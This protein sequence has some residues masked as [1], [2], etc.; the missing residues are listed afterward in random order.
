MAGFCALKSSKTFFNAG[1][2]LGS[3][4]STTTVME[5]DRAPVV[6]ATEEGAL[7][8]DFD[9]TDGD[10]TA[11]GAA[12][13]ASNGASTP[14][15]AMAAPTLSTSRRLLWRI[16]GLSPVSGTGS[17]AL[18]LVGERVW[19]AGQIPLASC[20]DPGETR[21]TRSVIGSRPRPA[22]LR[23]SHR[24]SATDLLFL[25][26]TLAILAVFLG[27]PLVYG[28]V[29][30]LHDTQ[31]FDLTSF[32]GLDHYARA[33]FGDAVFHRSLVNTL[34]FTGVAV[35]LQ[36][37]LGLF[38]AVLLADARRGRSFFQFVFFV[39]FVLA[40]VA[41][42]AVWKFLYA[43]YFG[44]GATVGSALGFDTLTVAP[45]ADPRTALWGIMAAF[46]WRFAGFN[47]VVYLAAIQALPPGYYEHAALEGAGK[48]QKFR[49]ITWPL[50]WPQTFTLVLLTTLGTLRIFDMIWIM[51]GGGPS[52]A[53]ETVATDIYT[54]AFS[55]LQV[56]YAQAMAMILL[57]V[58][59][60][61]AVAEYR[62]LNR[63][64]EMVSA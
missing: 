51:T 41:V 49:H 57:V 37:G 36:T 55:F 39:P 21:Q 46:L 13:A 4:P 10:A 59:L 62:I 52:H 23:R 12:H 44:V 45:L 2:V 24:E 28:I 33:I 9:A 1:S 25:L 38:L 3:G 56:G 48:F 17:M 40:S 14:P 47:M 58:I 34:L 5:P 32:V 50:L 18:L 29:L 53:T 6:E 20:S 30:S 11:F 15:A 54:T 42:G 19:S 26:P 35:V 7:P 31:G 27:Y 43:P 61:L 60:L 22:F 16:H 63:R 64:A 8:L